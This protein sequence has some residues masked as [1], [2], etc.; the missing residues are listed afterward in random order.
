MQHSPGGRNP[1]GPHRS[2]V[3]CRVPFR[4]VWWFRAASFCLCLLPI[5]PAPA[6]DA[7]GSAGAAV[8]ADSR[9]DSAEN[10]P[11][12]L[13]TQFASPRQLLRL[14]DIGESDLSSLRDGQPI[15][16]DDLEAL[17][18]ILYRMPQIG[19]DEIARWQHADVPWPALRADPSSARAEFFRLRGRVRKLA[20]HALTPRLTALFDFDHFYQ[21]DVELDDAQ[22]TAV[23]FTRVIPRAWEGHEELDERTCTPAMFVK[24]GDERG[25]AAA[26]MFAAPR[27]VWL[28][29]RVAS[30]L[31]VGAHQ[32]WLSRLGMDMGL[33]DDVR[34]RD[35]LPIGADEREC[36][37]AL[38]SAV[39][40]ADT[41]ELAREAE[42]APLSRLLQYPEQ[43]HGNIVQIAGR[44]R[45][46]TR[47][48][49]DERDVRQRFGI[50]AYYQLDILVPVGDQPIE[51]RGAQGEQAGPVY[52]ESFPCTCCAL[53]LPASWESLVGAPQV[54]RPVLMSGVFYKL[55]AYQNPLVAAYDPRQRQLSPMFIVG[56]P[57][58][59][60]PASLSRPG[61]GMLV[62]VGFGGLLVAVWVIVWAMNRSDR[63]QLRTRAQQRAADEQPPQFDHL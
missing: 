33:W 25:G 20:R 27:I 60:D 63:R 45:R 56:T 19:W 32:V 6:L 46:I 48:V 41:A 14:L 43:E 23:V 2:R 24:V 52:R 1:R 37:Y 62:G 34:A 5:L 15:G 54:N 58:A 18:K 13:A 17:I 4:R 36:F 55:W 11:R 9:P 42:P 26:L 31:G 10:P 50:S 16:P 22:G 28:P 7:I 29:D 44:L 53:Q 51:V 57:Q 3:I 38:L 59:W 21:L 30:D 35:R 49:V 40:Q 8:V 47:V 12:I 61:P 39:G